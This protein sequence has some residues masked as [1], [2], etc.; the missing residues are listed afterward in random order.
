M[1]DNKGE[2]T[3]FIMSYFLFSHCWKYGYH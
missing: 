3:I 1:C 2:W